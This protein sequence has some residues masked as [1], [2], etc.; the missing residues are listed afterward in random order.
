ML[1]P[2]CLR[3]AGPVGHHTLGNRSD[4]SIRPVTIGHSDSVGQSSSLWS[5]WR[6]R[7]SAVVTP[8]PSPYGWILDRVA[9]NPASAILPKSHH[10][11]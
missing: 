2:I 10:S 9:I 5:V 7:D 4:Q 3:V 11:S 8:L 1:Q 6:R